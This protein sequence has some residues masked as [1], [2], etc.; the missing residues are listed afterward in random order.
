MYHDESN[1]ILR[2]AKVYYYADSM[3]EENEGDY[4]HYDADEVTPVVWK[5]ET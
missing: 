2:D 3:P 5:K 4:W 1:S